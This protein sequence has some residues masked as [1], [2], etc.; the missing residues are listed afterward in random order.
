M[1]TVGVEGLLK[2]RRSHTKSSF[3]HSTFTNTNKVMQAPDSVVVCGVSVV[4][5]NSTQFTHIERWIA[6]HEQLH[7]LR[8]QH[9]PRTHIQPDIV[10]VVV[11]A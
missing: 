9:L 2:S 11:N 10:V 5:G 4:D 7:F 8:T 6:T 1:A 3:E